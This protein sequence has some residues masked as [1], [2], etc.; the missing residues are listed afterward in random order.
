MSILPK[1]IYRLNT[2][3]IKI[4]AGFLVEIDQ[5]F[6]KELQKT[7]KVEDITLHISRFLLKLQ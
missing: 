7:K 3:S 4:P 2:I 1:L 6:L 5:L